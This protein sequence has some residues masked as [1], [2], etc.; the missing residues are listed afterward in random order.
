MTYG[1][2]NARGC[3]DTATHR[4]GSGCFC[5]RHSDIIDSLVLDIAL[6]WED[7]MGAKNL[8]NKFQDAVVKLLTTVSAHILP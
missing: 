5:C 7:Y 4:R 2:C 1:T 3:S 6:M 8:V